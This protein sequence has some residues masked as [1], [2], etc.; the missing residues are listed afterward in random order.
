MM[1][2]YFGNAL[3]QLLVEIHENPEFRACFG[4]GGCLCS[5]VPIQVLLGLEISL[6]VL[7]ICWRVFW[8]VA[9]CF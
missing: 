7:V 5:L 8:A 2:T 9:C 4:I 1:G 3:F 6:K